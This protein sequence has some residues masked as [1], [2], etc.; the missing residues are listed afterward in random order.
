MYWG[1]EA[2][3]HKEKYPISNNDVG[4]SE[5]QT[6]LRRKKRWLE[7]HFPHSSTPHGPKVKAKRDLGETAH[8]LQGK[9]I[10]S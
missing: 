4:D 8:S 2:E 1:A 6:E 9:K 5:M 10:K 7:V 3:K